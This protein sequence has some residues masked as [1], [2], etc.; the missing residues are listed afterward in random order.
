MELHFANCDCCILVINF[1]TSSHP[2]EAATPR[3]L[4]SMGG[5]SSSQL[6]KGAT[7]L[8]QLSTK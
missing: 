7:I 5:N 3:P 2:S 6:E 1:V 4:E 8:V